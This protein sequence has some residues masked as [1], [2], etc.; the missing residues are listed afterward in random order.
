[1][2]AGER[3]LC[4]AFGAFLVSPATFFLK[5]EIKSLDDTTELFPPSDPMEKDLS[6]TL[7]ERRKVRDPMALNVW[8]RYPLG[9]M[10]GRS[11]LV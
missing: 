9:G 4:S 6:P 7:Q 1:M 5:N 11:R 10:L 8:D 2:P 3:G